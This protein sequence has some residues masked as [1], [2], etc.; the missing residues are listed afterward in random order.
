MRVRDEPTFRRLVLLL[1]LV[2]ALHGLLYVPLVELNVATDSGPY[3]ATADAILDG[4]YST[5]LRASFYFVYP[6]G[7]LDITGLHF[8][9][10]A[11][12]A[13]E[14]QAFRP[15]GYPLFLA[16][17]GGG[18]PGVPQTL[19]LLGQAVLFGVG[20]A[21]LALT[22]RRWGG[23]Q[24]G[25][26]AAAVYALDPWS[27]HYVAL[28]LS[29]TLAGTLA[30]ATAYATT[31]A[32][33]ER[34]VRWW[35]AAGALA[36]SLT[37]VRA[38]FVVAVPLVV[39]A[40]LLRAPVA[41]RLRAGGAAVAASAVLLVPWLAWT[42]SVVGTPVLASYGEGFNLLVAAHGEGYGR[43]FQEVITDPAFRRD[44]TAGHRFAPTAQRIQADAD[45]HPRY[46]RR[47][48]EE[49]RARARALFRERLR[50]EPAQVAWETLY[51]AWY[52]WSAHHDWY[53]PDGGELLVLEALDWL[54]LL[55]SAAGAVIAL[56]RGG[57]ARAIVVFLLVYTLAIAT[58]HVEARFAIPLRGF[59]L[60]LAVWA[61]LEA[62]GRLR[63]KRR[64]QEDG[65]PERH[66]GGAADG[67]DVG[68]RD[69]KHGAG[70]DDPDRG[71]R[72]QALVAVPG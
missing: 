40:A 8:R 11:W 63:R 72:D 7:F 64:Q 10:S 15:P 9:R 28:I 52:L 5:P 59:Q 39:L 45:A 12:E 17:T 62:A 22:A 41:G 18:G 71:P 36:A 46:V 30:L 34:S 47:V 65:E 55:L 56:R 3:V 4:D 21:L 23:W 53:Q 14:R 69:R 44:F 16:A 42:W 61:V 38:V 32:W 48:D 67:E 27:K 33:Q 26:A 25:L 29:E 2:G 35:A 51:R 57:P 66:R 13:P 24:L 1:A 68:L 58:H 60:T 19:A 31:R 37:L 43:S 49:Q 6:T 50:D 54:L 20:V 70:G